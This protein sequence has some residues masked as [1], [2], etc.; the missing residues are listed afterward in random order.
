MTWATIESLPWPEG[1]YREI[2]FKNLYHDDDSLNGSR[3]SNRALLFN[4]VL[5][6]ALLSLEVK[7]FDQALNCLK[8]ITFARLQFDEINVPMSANPRTR[9]DK[10]RATKLERL[11]ETLGTIRTIKRADLHSHGYDWSIMHGNLLRCL[12]QVK[13]VSLHGGLGGIIELVPGLVGHES[14]KEI[15]LHLPVECYPIILP[16]LQ[17]LP[18]LKKVAVRSWDSFLFRADGAPGVQAIANLLATGKSG[19]EVDIYSLHFEDEA[20]VCFCAGAAVTKIQSLVMDSCY[21]HDPV[22]FADAI[23]TSHL[24]QVKLVDLEFGGSVT[25][26]L[27]AFAAGLESMPQLEMLT[28]RPSHRLVIGRNPRDYDAAMAA[29]V[30]ALVHCP[31]LK[32]VK[33]N[34]FAYS[35][36]LDD[37]LADCIRNVSLLEEVRVDCRCALN[38]RVLAT[39]P[40]LLQAMDTNY[41]LKRVQLQPRNEI[42]TAKVKIYLTLNEAGRG[43]MASDSGN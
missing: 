19:L 14:I 31:S 28:C 30:R 3:P 15:E 35:S 40:L 6:H 17:T 37:A 39:Y 20:N 11:C 29:L 18:L 1:K 27:N 41:S 33:V 25:T 12:K 23:A 16:T 22:M 38:G 5:M 24:K 36:E 26:F 32:T 7:K 34:I 43:Y 8:K 9:G 10:E 13:M 21:L 42:T 2:L 4:K